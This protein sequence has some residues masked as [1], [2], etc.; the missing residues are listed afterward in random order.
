MNIIIYK[1]ASDH[2]MT[3]DTITTLEQSSDV[4]Q[5]I[6]A[7]SWLAEMLRLVMEQP[8]TWPR[9]KRKKTDINNSGTDASISTSLNHPQL[10]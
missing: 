9:L 5:E 10:L 1:L 3:I 8:E 2:Q 4:S 6:T 7:E